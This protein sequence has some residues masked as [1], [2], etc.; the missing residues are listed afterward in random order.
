[1]YIM[2]FVTL[3]GAL[4]GVFSQ[5]YVKQS[6]QP[7]AQQKGISSAMAIWQAAA[8]TK[9]LSFGTANFPD[10]SASASPCSLTNI[11]GAALPAPLSNCGGSVYL[12]SSD[13]PVGYAFS[14]YAFYSLAYKTGSSGPYYVLTFV[15]PPAASSDDYGAG[16]L[17]L[18]GVI[19]GSGCPS[20]NVRLSSMFNAFYK[21]LGNNPAVS[22][23]TF[24]VVTSSGVL[25]AKDSSVETYTVPSSTIVPVGSLAI[26]R[27]VGG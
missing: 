25:T 14:T 15:P 11:G 5:I 1:M 8:A 19:S 17:C 2:L 3:M 9:A 6:A 22:L 27:A 21:D 7:F 18:P 20:P 24:G 26:I 23:Q 13:M 10:L 4:I 12:A 16:F